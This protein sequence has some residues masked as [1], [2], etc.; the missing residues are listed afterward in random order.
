M[1][2]LTGTWPQ[3]TALNS[4]QIKNHTS[5]KEVSLLMTLGTLAIVVHA[6]TRRWLQ[7]PGHQGMTLIALFVIG[8]SRSEFRWAAMTSSVGAAG[9]SMMPWWS[10]NDPF[11]WITLGLA[12]ATLDVL[13]CHFAKV[14]H[15][16]WYLVCAGGA[17]HMTKP[18]FRFILAQINGWPY[19][20]LRWGVMYPSATHFLFGTLGAMAGIAIC[21]IGFRTESGK[22]GLEPE[23]E[24]N[25]SNSRTV[26][27]R[28]EPIE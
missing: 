21:Q 2:Y 7:I 12:G 13:Y 1:L 17:S 4:S 14:R 3:E 25:Q 26:Q 27:E 10:F 11:R 22:S 20:S 9:I 15:N 28:H 5:L 6:A 16:T 8:R 23:S 18:L 19:G 24:S